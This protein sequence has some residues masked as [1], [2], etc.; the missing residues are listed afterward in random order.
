[1]RY[2]LL[3]LV[4]V[5]SLAGFAAQARAGTEAILIGGDGV[6]EIL[7]AAADGAGGQYVVYRSGA[8]PYALSVQYANSLGAAVWGPVLV[9]P[10]GNVSD[11][12]VHRLS[13]GDLMV[14]YLTSS[15]TGNSL[16]AQPVAPP[17]TLFGTHISAIQPAGPSGPAKPL[18][19]VVAV[20]GV[21]GLGDGVVVLAQGVGLPAHEWLFRVDAAGN[22]L[23]SRDAGTFDGAW[24]TPRLCL[25]PFGESVVVRPAAQLL[26]QKY[27][28]AGRP[29]WNGGSDLVATSVSGSKIAVEVSC[30]AGGNTLLTW[31][32]RRRGPAALDQFVQRLSPTGQVA[33]PD[34]VEVQRDVEAGNIAIAADDS[35][36]AFL[37]MLRRTPLEQ[38]P[39]S[40]ARR[41]FVAHLSNVGLGGFAATRMDPATTVS[42]RGAH[43][44]ADGRGGV[45]VE[46]R[47]DPAI[48]S[49]T[50]ACL[51]L[52]WLD[53]SVTSAWGT[54]PTRTGQ[55]NA[56]EALDRLSV[57][58][59]QV[60]LLW[61]DPR[62]GHT[63][64]Y[65]WTSP[66]AGVLGAPAPP[67]PAA[68]APAPAPI[69]PNKAA[70][71][72]EP[73]GL[74][75]APPPGATLKAPSFAPR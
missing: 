27:D 6:H 54:D 12:S 9:A 41:L 72:P 24:S 46:W 31:Q 59:G 68:S 13:S 36:G 8:G 52:R 16:F 69:L 21:V 23:W 28:G 18:G 20:H 44:A 64:V 58:G 35:G 60:A 11:A 32:D 53:G 65:R 61:S 19:Q 17:R 43:L 37:A 3:G 4:L 34:G 70:L 45:F 56:S 50:L 29:M 51:G 15:P 7:D 62:S 71:Q 38:V 55:C 2:R 75:P 47:T 1:M 63:N 33:W 40:T 57:Q 25:T 48:A 66:A 42:Q 39:S 26:A 67:T 73:R 30:D 14:T 22:P 49:N 74:L 10:P 5:A